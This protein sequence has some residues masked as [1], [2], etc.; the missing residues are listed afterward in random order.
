MSTKLKKLKFKNFLS[1]GNKGIDFEFKNDK[2]IILIFG[3]NGTGKSIFLDALFYGLT[4]KPFRNIKINSVV[5]R[6]N[7]ENTQVE[8]ILEK[9]KDTYKIIRGLKPKTFLIYKN[10]IEVNETSH[11]NLQRH[12]ENDILEGSKN[13]LSQYIINDKFK[14]FMKLTKW[15]K[16]GF[17]EEMINYLVVFSEMNR[18]INMEK[19]KLNSKLIKNNT[20]MEVEKTNLNNLKNN[21]NKSDSEIRNEMYELKKELLNIKKEIEDLPE[22]EASFKEISDKL[23]KINEVE[24]KVY[25]SEQRLKNLVKKHN[26]YEKENGNKLECPHCGRIIDL[27]RY[28]ENIN[29]DDVLTEL[30]KVENNLKKLLDSKNK[31]KNKRTQIKKELDN[32]KKLKDRAI[33]YKKNYTKLKEKQGN[34]TEDLDEKIKEVEKTIKKIDENRFKLNQNYR[35]F[36]IIQDELICDDGLRRIIIRNIVPYINNKIAY[37]LNLFN[38]SSIKLRFDENFDANL[39]MRGEE[40]SYNSCSEGEKRRID[41][42]ILFAFLN[43]IQMKSIFKFNTVIFDEIIDNNLDTKSIDIFFKIIESDKLFENKNVIVISHKE[44]SFQ[45]FDRVIS[46]QKNQYTQYNEMEA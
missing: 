31:F 5:N 14:N 15:E 12:L 30:E 11:T 4:G 9:G 8:L 41:F 39:T 27:F 13:L 6:L 43:F 10:G 21:K 1:A 23:D 7:R 40:V 45:N 28:F 2:S 22:T 32:K 42:S 37:Y 18:I 34:L 44:V 24:K 33:L 16:R 3:E 25:S 38:Y 19:N 36:E 46:V 20:E 26:K 29:I 17:L 35:Y